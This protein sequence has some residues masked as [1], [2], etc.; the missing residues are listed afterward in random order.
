L[1]AEFEWP[2]INTG[3]I[4]QN[5]N[6]AVR[7]IIALIIMTVIA[8]FASGAPPIAGEF[9]TGDESVRYIVWFHS[10]VHAYE[11]GRDGQGDELNLAPGDEPGRYSVVQK[12]EFPFLSYITLFRA[13][14][15]P[16]DIF[17]DLPGDQFSPFGYSVYLNGD[18]S[19]PLQPA[20]RRGDNCLCGGLPCGEQWVDNYADWANLGGNDLWFGLDWADSTPAAPQIKC[21]FLP[22]VE[23]YNY[24]GIGIA[25]YYSWQNISYCPVFRYQFLRP[26]PGDTVVPSGWRRSLEYDRQPDSFL[27]RC[28][29]IACDSLIARFNVG[30]DTLIAR[31]PDNAIDSVEICAYYE[32]CHEDSCLVLVYDRQLTSPI[33]A[34]VDFEKE[35]P[36]GSFDLIVNNT[37]ISTLNLTLS[38]NGSVLENL[39]EKINLEGN[40]TAVIPVQTPLSESDSLDLMIIIRDQ[41][42]CYYPYLVKTTYPPPSPLDVEDEGINVSPV[43]AGFD[44]YPNPVH[45]IMTIRPEKHMAVDQIEIFNVI[46][47]KVFEKRMSQGHEIIWEGCDLSGQRLPAGIYFVRIR[48]NKTVVGTRQVILVR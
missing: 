19:L 12:S 10:E 2:I 1:T 39:P 25:E 31:L 38:H 34:E 47:Q 37:G 4:N 24:L 35:S 14:I 5:R 43:R 48:D 6:I 44:L 3:L 42:G 9:M 45:D 18:D 15:N 20:V 36:S 21:I 46:G 33:R 26:F 40:Q 28:Y 23:A 8:D 16:A 29:D 41:D 22:Q 7:N 13:K 30:T 11:Q 17:P 27:I 32:N